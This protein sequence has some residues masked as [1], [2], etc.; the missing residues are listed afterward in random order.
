MNSSPE[1]KLFGRWHEIVMLLLGFSLTG[2]VGTVL[3]A[4]FQAEGQRLAALEAQREA[5]RTR[6]EALREAARAREA[7]RRRW[8][9]ERA[10]EFYRDFS[11]MLDAR[12]YHA[13][14]LALA[15]RDQSGEEKTRRAHEDYLA[16]VVEWNVTLNRNLAFCELYFGT[17]IAAKFEPRIASKMRS[18]HSRLLT[19]SGAEAA[20]ALGEIDE[21]GAMIYDLNLDILRLL[22]Q[23]D[24][25]SFRVA[26]AAVVQ[27]KSVSADR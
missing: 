21:V 5:D 13:L 10:S 20:T 11:R 23:G 12:R 14:R 1:A 3:T 25:G 15:Y 16:A 18:I 2:I 7:E 8:E 24:V 9:L 4:R 17:G 27:V 26:Q 19:A 6:E 22:Q